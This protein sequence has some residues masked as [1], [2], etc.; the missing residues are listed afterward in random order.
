MAVTDKCAAADRSKC[1]F[2]G[3]LDHAR[4]NVEDKKAKYEEALAEY[5]AADPKERDKKQNRYASSSAFVNKIRNTKTALNKAQGELDAIPSE[6]K[7]LT[8]ELKVAEAAGEDTKELVARKNKALENQKYAKAKKA[9]E[10][11]E[12]EEE[13]AKRKEFEALKEAKKNETSSTDWKTGYKSAVSA[14]IVEQGVIVQPPTNPYDW[15]QSGSRVDW[16]KTNHLRK[17]GALDVRNIEEESSVEWPH[18]N[19]FDEGQS[20]TKYTVS[21]DATCNCGNLIKEKIEVNDTFNN[22]LTSVLKF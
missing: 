14:V 3:V 17:C 15:S 22:I 9:T 7:K 11:R 1:R 13:I 20:E 5:E 16:E 6:Y 4:M 18:A 10:K 19:S 21:A 12:A 2:H 8:A